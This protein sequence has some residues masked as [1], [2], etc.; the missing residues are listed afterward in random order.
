MTDLL[1]PLFLCIAM[2]IFNIR[3]FS[4]RKNSSLENTRKNASS[5]FILIIVNL[6]FIVYIA[7]TLFGID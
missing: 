5:F 6:L 3:A 2:V 4:A 7:L 1:F